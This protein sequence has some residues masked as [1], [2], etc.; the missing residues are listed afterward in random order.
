[1]CVL[2]DFKRMM[3]NIKKYIKKIIKVLNGSS[4]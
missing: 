3:E 4:Y 1:M 2:L